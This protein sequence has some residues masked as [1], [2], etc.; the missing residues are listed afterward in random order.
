MEDLLVTPRQKALFALLRDGG[1]SEGGTDAKGER[2]EDA[3]PVGLTLMVD[4]ALNSNPDEDQLVDLLTWGNRAYWEQFRPL[5]RKILAFVRS[6]GGRFASLEERR[7]EVLADAVQRATSP[8]PFVNMFG[9]G[10]VERLDVLVRM[11]DGR[12]LSLQLLEVD[13]Y[14]Q[15]LVCRDECGAPVSIPLASVTAVWQYRR[16]IHRSLALW[17]GVVL[18]GGLGAASILS[19]QGSRIL[20]GGIAFGALLG[21]LA[22]LGALKLFDDWEAFYELKQ[23]YPDAGG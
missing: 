14:D 11:K 12:E 23:L 2:F 6:A 22:G 15:Q 9:R 8:S 4:M 16:L 5:A 7:Y 10:A 18:V 20:V 19:G 13:L 3:S 1:G 21:A 17:F